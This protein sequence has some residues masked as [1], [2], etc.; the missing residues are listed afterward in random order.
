MTSKRIVSSALRCTAC[1]RHVL[2]AFVGAVNP[3]IKLSIREALPQTSRQARRLTTTST[4]KSDVVTPEEVE[5]RIHS[6]SSGLAALE[7]EVGIEAAAEEESQPPPEDISAQGEATPWYLETQDAEPTTHPFA[8]RQRLPD[9][10]LNPPPILQQLL[11]HI[12]VDLGLDYLNLIDLRLMDPPPALGANLIML[13]GTA[14]S[15]K[16]LNVSAD[17]LCRWLRTNYKLSPHA[18][19]LLGRNEL[20]LKLRRKARRARMLGAAGSTEAPSADDGIST[21]WVCVDV[22]SVENDPDAP[23]EEPWGER[24]GFIGFGRRTDQARIVVQMMTEEKRGDVDL[25]GLWQGMLEREGRKKEGEKRA[26]EKREHASTDRL[27][28]DILEPN[29]GIVHQRHTHA[30]PPTSS[31][32]YPAQQVRRYHTSPRLH[33]ADDVRSILAEEEQL[34]EDELEPHILPDGLAPQA[35]PLSNSTAALTLRT[36]VDY[37]KKLKPSVA[38]SMLGKGDQDF[39][40]TA[41]LSTFHS[42]M[43][44]FPDLEHHLSSIDLHCHALRL[45]A[46]GYTRSHLLH[47][48]RKIQMSS[49]AIPEET[50]YLGLEAL[51]LSPHSLDATSVRKDPAFDGLNAVRRTLSSAFE[52]L[53]Q[54][55]ANGYEPRTERA[56]LLVLDGIA[57]P[58]FSDPPYTPEA[59]R[60]YLASYALDKLLHQYRRSLNYQ[61]IYTSL[62]SSPASLTST[63]RALPAPALT[64]IHLSLLRISLSHALP[65]SI[66][67]SWRSLPR[68]LLPRP[69]EM[70]AVLFNGIADIESQAVALQTLETCVP[71]MVRESP[72]V[73]MRGEVARGVVRLLR[74]A[75]VDVGS[76]VWRTW[77]ERAREGIEEGETVGEEMEAGSI[78]DERR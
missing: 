5:R 12:S 31:T 58:A 68:L 8:E 2:N 71:E 7:A 61:P 37:I 24:E 19:G 16:H 50:F 32:P 11:K 57:N 49:Y 28:D 56:F 1:Q 47:L 67:A 72:R 3:S 46:P 45:S 13:F 18:D 77:F 23:S 4:R 43:P 64:S 6:S 60:M 33:R 40:S 27:D 39:D 63:Q 9:L 66:W 42:A 21:G 52:L 36:H 26:K 25:E 29:S 22:G 51:L 70:Y 74:V 54:M 78:S 38:L 41:F 17:R 65:P 59:E 14:R 35:G 48:F 69:A 73:E 53:E 75:G 34:N 62:T 44:S 30:F 20:K 15:E 10:P 55:E 76:G